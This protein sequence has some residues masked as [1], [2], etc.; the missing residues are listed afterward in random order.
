MAEGVTETFVGWQSLAALSGHE[1]AEVIERAGGLGEWA[2]TH[3][4][5][6]VAWEQRAP[7]V[8]AGDRLVHGDLRGDNVILDPEHLWIV[9]WPH[10]AV[11][12]PWLDLVC[13]LPSVAM[14]GGGP[15]HE[16]FA[17]SPLAA[18]VSRDELLAFLAGVAGFFTWGSLQPDPPGLPNLRAFQRAQAYTSVEWLREVAGE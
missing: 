18:E 3:L 6:L 1:R 15:A 4:D 8:S 2:A 16:I 13:M 14:Q 5:Q 17:A 12:A 11:G 7:E 10:A 9:D